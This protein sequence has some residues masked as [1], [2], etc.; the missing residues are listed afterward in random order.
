[1]ISN[2]DNSISEHRNYSTVSKTIIEESFI[3]EIKDKKRK[4]LKNFFIFQIILVLLDIISIIICSKF[5]FTFLNLILKILF[6][7]LIIFALYIL[8]S[9]R[10]FY[11]LK[12]IYT[13]SFLFV[14]LFFVNIIILMYTK[15]LTNFYG[16]I[17]YFGSGNQNKVII[18]YFCCLLYSTLNLTFPITSVILMRKAIMI[19]QKLEKKLNKECS[20]IEIL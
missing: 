12:K 16:L 2:N 15:I 1:M 8:T 4:E 11:L 3:N 10:K 6:C 14:F 18:F 13:L 19:E 9:G 7:I 5:L 20:S 17:N